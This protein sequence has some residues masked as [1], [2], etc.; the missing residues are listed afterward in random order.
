MAT[1]PVAGLPRW[2]DTVTAD[3]KRVSTPTSGKLDVGYAG[4]EKP[5]AQFLNWFKNLTYQWLGWAEESIDD[6]EAADVAID[7][8]LDAI[9]AL[10]ITLDDRLD[11]LEARGYEHKYVLPGNAGRF[12]TSDA[13]ITWGED[14][15]TVADSA[16]VV[17][18]PLPVPSWM[19]GAAAEDENWVLKSV[20]AIVDVT[21]KG[22][23]AVSMI[24]RKYTLGLDG[25]V[26]VTGTVG[27]PDTSLADAFLEV[28]DV[29][30]TITSVGF[31]NYSV[32][33]SFTGGTAGDSVV[34]RSVVA[35][36]TRD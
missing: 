29:N 36:Y 20:Q 4:S 13:D 14:G 7:G 10:D 3:P 22:T 19:T 21:D 1:K 26:S 27:T 11:H 24:V 28:G 8:R 34:I 6:L 9:E 16:G 2:A 23:F 35:T 17:I 18:Y 15:I 12:S 31:E 5:A 32:R 25:S 33:F 30:E